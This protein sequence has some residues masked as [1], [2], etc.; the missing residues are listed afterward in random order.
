MIIYGAMTNTSVGRLYAAGVIPGL[1]LTALFMLIIVVACWWKPAFA[2]AVEAPAP[3]GVRLRRLVD[4]RP[5]DHH[6]RGGDGQHL[7][8]LGD[9][10]RVGGARRRHV[11]RSS[12]PR[13][14][15]CR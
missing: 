9:A 7:P 6:L 15:P 14:G 2:G 10:D 4:L 3:L 11:A 13:T 5:A 8:R 1:L 12:A